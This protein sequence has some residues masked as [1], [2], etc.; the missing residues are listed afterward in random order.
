[1]GAQWDSEGHVTLAVSELEARLRVSSRVDPAVEFAAQSQTN[2]HI[3][4]STF[5]ADCKYIFKNDYLQ[6]RHRKRET[7]R[8]MHFGKEQKEVREIE[9]ATVKVRDSPN[10][11]KSEI[12]ILN[13]PY[14]ALPRHDVN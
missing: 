6:H 1:M 3:T 14:T 11:K 5:H 2:Q 12:N 9:D 4:W 10:E 7:V 13:R 8:V